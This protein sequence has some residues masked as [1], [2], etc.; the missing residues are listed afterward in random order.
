MNK[1]ASFWRKSILN[2][3]LGRI[4]FAQIERKWGLNYKFFQAC[5]FFFKSSSSFS[6]VKLP[7]QKGFSKHIL[8][9]IKRRIFD[10]NFQPG[11]DRNCPQKR[12]QRAYWTNLIF[13]FSIF[14]LRRRFPKTIPPPRFAARLRVRGRLKTE[15][16]ILIE[17]S[18]V[19]KKMWKKRKGEKGKKKSETKEPLEPRD[20]CAI[21]RENCDSFF[22]AP[23]EP[24]S[25]FSHAFLR[26]YRCQDYREG[27]LCVYCFAV[28]YGE[29]RPGRGQDFDPCLRFLR[30][31]AC[32]SRRTIS[33]S[34]LRYDDLGARYRDRFDMRG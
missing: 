15:R 2:E 14:H 17:S 25:G 28:E 8:R 4:K 21:L 33:L 34:R 3:F 22:R 29:R 11:E 12:A 30:A 13:A 6:T 20:T 1:K 18:S 32:V 24:A 10:V 26:N 5:F 23:F 31:S 27:R 19:P 9:R 16:K 7:S